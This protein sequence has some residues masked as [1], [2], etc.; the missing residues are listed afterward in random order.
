MQQN[1]HIYASADA[2]C[3]VLERNLSHVGTSARKGTSQSFFVCAGQQAA[4]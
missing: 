2:C 3:F 1:I 4:S